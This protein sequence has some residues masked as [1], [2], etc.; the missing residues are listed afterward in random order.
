VTWAHDGNYYQF[1]ADGTDDGKFTI[2]NVR[3]GSYTLY[4]F[5]DGVLGELAQT[6]ISVVAG[7]TLDL[8]KIEW[9]PVRN[10]R[11]LWEIGVPN[12]VA[13]EFYKGDGANYWL[14]GWPVRYGGL[15]PDDITYT[16]GK[17]E[18]RK[19]WFFQQ[20]PHQLSGAWKNPGAK[21]PL[22]QPFGWLRTAAA[23][24]DLW[25]TIGRGRA[26]T[27]TIKFPM[28][29]AGRGQ[30]SLRVA[31]A[32]ADGNGGLAVAVN[33][34]N[35]G[36]IRPTATNALRY[37]TDKGVWQERVQ[38]FDGALLKAGEN[39]IQL[40]VPAGEVTSGVVYDYLRLEL[41]DD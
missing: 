36:T 31:L 2:S 14:W 33:G 23:G 24:E 37:N 12:R 19:D 10:G 17:S 41:K 1:W 35:V 32:G 16:I 20:V 26:T 8:G 30:A 11:Q 28:D 4:A 5:A 38:T 22:H 3:P 21:D 6:N 7:Q 9:K 13:S 25:R 29:E 18:G 40:T 27:W 34:Q 39:Q 15:F